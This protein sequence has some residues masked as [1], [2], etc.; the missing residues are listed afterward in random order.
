MTEFQSP[1][2]QAMAQSG[3][4]QVG[5]EPAPAATPTP[6]PAAE[7]VPV[8]PIPEVTPPTP[9]PSTFDETKWLTEKFAGK[10]KSA[11]ELINAI[12]ERED[13][14]T[15]YSDVEKKYLDLETKSKESPFAND[16]VKGLND[17]M[18]KGGD[19]A[20]YSKVQSL[21]LGKLSERDTL[22]TKY[23]VQYNMSKTDAEF[24]VDRKYMLQLGEGQTEND[25]DVREARIDLR[26]DSAEAK[27]YLSKYKT[28]AMV[29]PAQREAETAERAK[30]QNLESWKPYTGQLVDSLK[31]V[32]I[33]IDDKGGVIQFPVSP[34]TMQHIQE[35]LQN[36]LETTGIPPDAKGQALMKDILLR[37][38]FFAHNKD[39]ALAVATAKDVAW[40]KQTSNPSALRQE[41]VPPGSVVKSNDQLMAEAIAKSEGFKYRS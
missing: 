19:A 33:P 17:F 37:E 16:Y 11:D 15:K 21:D 32:E 5:S 34:S 22:V 28:E 39:I 41:A 26:M 3:F 12:K 8:V 40:V 10:Y 31:S 1:L 24:K 23:R 35:H 27:E 9:T 20:T 38:V 2:E 14:S 36:V 13:L 7:A 4:T 29:P 30:A 18:K 25:P 6:A